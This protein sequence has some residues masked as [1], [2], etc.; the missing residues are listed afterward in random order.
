M[1][2]LAGD[3]QIPFL[4]QIVVI[5]G[6]SIL[7]IYL[8][9]RLRLPVI[10]GFLAT[11]MIF[12]PHG[13]GLA[14]AGDEIEVLSEIGVILLL[15]I[16][17]LEFSLKH[18]MSIRKVVLMGGSLQ[19]GL[20]IAFTALGGI[21]IGME[22]NSAVFMGFLFALSST[23]IVLKI[24][25]EKGLM[26]TPQGRIAIGILIFQD[27]I[28]VPM[29]L[30]TPILAG[31]AG[32]VLLELLL[33]SVKFALVIVMVYFGARYLVPKL[34]HEIALTRSRE[35]F[36][37]TIIVICFAVAYITSMMGLSLALGAFMA[38]LCISESEYSHQATGLIIPFR[39][40]FTSFFFVSIGMLFDL[41]FLVDHLLPILGFAVGVFVLKFVVLVLAT[42]L[43]KYSL[44]TGFVV[45]FTMFQVGE[46][47]FILATVGISNGLI[48]AELYQYFLAVSI[49][50][51]ALT[52]F[53]ISY[54]DRIAGRLMDSPVGK[55][56]RVREAEGLSDDMDIVTKQLKGHLIIVGYGINGKAV[57]RTAKEAKID[58]III[59][60]NPELVREARENGE[61][62]IYGNASS[63]HLLEQANLYKARVAMVA[64]SDHEDTLAI[65]SNM[66]MLCRSVHIIVRCSTLAQSEELLQAGASEVVSE[67][68]ETSIE[69]FARTLNQFLVSQGEIDAYIELIRDDAYKG[70]HSSYHVYKSDE[71]S[72][73][74]LHTA[75]V[76]LTES[77]PFSEKHLCDAPLL[78]R[79]R[80]RI[81]GIIRDGE[82]EVK[83]DGD[84]MM[85]SG[86]LLIIAGRQQDL[87]NFK[88]DWSA[89]DDT[90]GVLLQA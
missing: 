8:F 40:I 51:M 45:G 19:V 34:L 11:G 31:N 22:A 65:V 82:Y 77:C 39:E 1:V 44:K 18:L 50:T 46:F 54:A 73:K 13:L 2:L 38:G 88:E 60:M 63:D 41:G 59:D 48:D 9:Q 32:N 49:I 42:R 57:A 28:V 10:L 5:L 37:I 61:P 68:F 33:L 76:R 62:I 74:D 83:L 29:M 81:L 64:V 14:R 66:R 12:G 89:Q 4:N 35:L 3:I 20:T 72:L 16:I 55:L 70:I 86:D 75:A 26:Q 53:T 24:V 52:P 56:Q 30:L 90:K 43:L 79:H 15:F 21:L 87:A 6:L 78:S 17:G 58:Y 25:Q 69:V 80:I 85:H 84:S 23:A 36:L 67:K 27:I 71:L 7:V 47:A